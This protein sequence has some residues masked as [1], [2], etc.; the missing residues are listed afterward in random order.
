[1]I[2]VQEGKEEGEMWKKGKYARGKDSKKGVGIM[3]L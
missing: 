1:M 3:Q 2:T